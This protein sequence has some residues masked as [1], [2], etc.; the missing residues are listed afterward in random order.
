MRRPA[1]SSPVRRRRGRRARQ[2]PPRPCG[3]AGG[4]WARA[5]R[6][7][8]RQFASGSAVVTRSRSRTARPRCT[9]RCS[10]SASGRATRSSCRRSRSWR[11]PTPIVAHRRRARLLRH[12]RRGRPQP[13]PRRP[14]GGDHAATQAIVVLHYGGSRARSTTCWRSRSRGLAVVEDAAHALGATLDGRS[15]RHVRR[16][17]LLQLLLEQEPAGRRGRHGRD[18]RRRAR[19]AA[20]PAALARDDDAH[21]GPAP[22]PRASYDVVDVGFNYRLDEIRA[23]LAS[24]SSGAS[25]RRTTP[26]AHRRPLPPRCSTASTASRRLRRAATTRRLG[27]PPRGRPPA[28]GR[29]PRRRAGRAAEDRIQTSVHYPP[30]HRFTAYAGARRH[31][32]CAH[33]RRRADRLLTLPLYPH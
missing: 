1:G 12:P 33:G 31:A 24:C 15:V 29:R 9:S 17:R 13:R 4:A 26:A 2:A 32:P 30:I 21:L 6:S 18:R 20:P 14:R 3:P 5:W 11:R 23:A 10:P 16:R 19:R 22:W 27:A 7:S 8:R 28:R 25:P